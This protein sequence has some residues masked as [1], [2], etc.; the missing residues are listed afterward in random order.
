MVARTS[1]FLGCQTSHHS[2]RA[3]ISHLMHKPHFI[4]NTAGDKSVRAWLVAG[5]VRNG[6]ARQNAGSEIPPNGLALRHDASAI[7]TIRLRASRHRNLRP[8]S[9]QLR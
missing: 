3:R 8:G 5:S 6:V 1:M 4:Y 9:R 2:A 7:M